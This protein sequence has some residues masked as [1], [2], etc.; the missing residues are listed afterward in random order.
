MNYIERFCKLKSNLQKMCL[1]KV[2]DARNLARDIID[3]ERSDSDT[4]WRKLWDKP[5]YAN[6]RVR[7]AD[8]IKEALKQILWEYDKVE[9]RHAWKLLGKD[10]SVF[11]IEKFGNGIA[12]KSFR[13]EGTLAK[14]IG[15]NTDPKIALHRLYYIQQAAGALRQRDRISDFPFS[16]LIDCAEERI[17]ET[18]SKLMKE[19]GAGWGYVTV[20]HALTDMGLA[21]KPDVH[22]VRTM[23]HLGFCSGAPVDR[24]PTK[25]QAC[26]TV[27]DV[28]RLQKELENEALGAVWWGEPYA[29][30]DGDELRGMARRRRLRWLDKI[31]MEISRCGLLPK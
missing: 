26:R 2:C 22:L 12:R 29:K 19:F 17:E 11:R 6:L 20:L 7:E 15:E 30:N 25:H 28:K 14:R 5:I 16:D 4:C 9:I 24:V 23:R 1:R 18:V 8:R 10:S 27:L 31:L 3:V 13:L 21:V